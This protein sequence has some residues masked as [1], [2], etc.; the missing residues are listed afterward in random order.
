[1]ELFILESGYLE[2]RSKK[3]KVNKSGRMDQHMRDFGRTTKQMDLGESFM[4][5]EMFMKASLWMIR[6]M[7]M[8][9]IKIMMA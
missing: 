3:V 5:M 7:A 1:M 9:S 2:L 8:V 4:Q 6:R